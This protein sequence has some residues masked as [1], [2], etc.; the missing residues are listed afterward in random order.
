MEADPEPAPAPV[1]EPESQ[2]LFVSQDPDTQMQRETS[3]PP[4]TQTRASRK[5]AATP[6]SEDEDVM[7][8]MAPTTA[9]IKR[10]RL[11]Q[12]L[13]RKRRGESTPPP[14][15]VP[16]VKEEPSPMLAPAKP[17]PKRSRKAKEASPDPI[18]EARIRREEAEAAERAE[19][20]ALEA[21]LDG[22]GI[23]DIRKKLVIEEIEVVR[24]KPPPRVV[25][26]ADE[27][28][29]WE[30]KWNGR[31]NFKRFRRRGADESQ[32]R[33]EKVIV[34]LEEVK[35]RN[36]GIGDEYWGEER[37]NTQKRKGQAKGKGKDT[38]DSAA[39]SQSV[40]H[41]A[42][43]NEPSSD[44]DGDDRLVISQ[45]SQ[46]KP[47]AQAE[48]SDSDL[49]IITKPAPK[50]TSA[51]KAKAT[52]SSSRTSQSQTLADKPRNVSVEPVAAVSRK[53]SAPAT[54]SKAKEPP[55]KKTRQTSLRPAVRQESEDESDDGLK[56]KLKK[57]KAR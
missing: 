31:K 55:A 9:A 24:T 23:D 10:R 42:E 1:E 37:D 39:T 46:H 30:D 4:V 32:R 43:P 34:A 6:L 51:S 25:A 21:Q 20:E 17:V 8:V 2:G 57:R 3:H 50:K 16:V 38:Q 18:E 7:E 26:H 29:R 35:N 56:F 33:V 19:R 48:S 52:A 11:A 14:P 49:E 47:S 36:Y 53:R 41:A 54:A 40:S 12:E 27:S 45:R 22:L 28:E 13:D 44:S 15:P 5:R